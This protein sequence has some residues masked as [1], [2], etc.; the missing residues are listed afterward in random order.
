MSSEKFCLRKF[1][2][3]IQN[4]ENSKN[5]LVRLMSNECLMLRI[6]S[7]SSIFL[8]HYIEMGAFYNEI[9]VCGVQTI[10]PHSI[11]FLLLPSIS[12][13]CYLLMLFI[14]S[15]LSGML[16]EAFLLHTCLLPIRA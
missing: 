6:P 12:S 7:F 5:S 1:Q 10:A 9:P 2:E 15:K 4:S 16:E 8:F 13:H 11:L 14:L 3:L